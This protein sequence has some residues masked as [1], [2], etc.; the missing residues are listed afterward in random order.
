M[1]TTIKNIR[2]QFADRWFNNIISDDGTLEILGASFRA[3]EPSIF[4][5]V[6]HG[7]IL[8]ELIWYQGMSLSVED[9][10]DPVPK[11][12][13]Q[14]SSKDGIINS[15]YGYL[16]LSEGNGSQFDHVVEA[17]LADPSTRRAV[18]IYQRPTM[19]VDATVDG[20]Q[21]FVCTNAVHYEIRESKLHV[22]VQMRSND[23]VFGYRNDYAW[24]RYAQKLVLA[25]IRDQ[26]LQHV[27][28]GD[29]FW[30]VASLHV[31]PRHFHLVER[32]AQTGE[33]DVPV[34]RKQD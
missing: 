30:Q 11:I 19:H 12:W 13:Q 14:V 32:Y 17:L 1:T 15:N 9:L 29:I 16:L 24:Q 31:Y 7:Y 21:D 6:N 23:A 33:W 34:S 8:Q 4:G 5:E 3:T 27:G 25:S 20:M 26:G 18:A 22:V 28:L 10:G 2:D